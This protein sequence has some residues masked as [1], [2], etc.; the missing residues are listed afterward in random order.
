MAQPSMQPLLGRSASGGKRS[1][2]TGL[3]EAIVLMC[4]QPA[5]TAIVH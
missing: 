5:M 3:L 1:S 4:A 2:T